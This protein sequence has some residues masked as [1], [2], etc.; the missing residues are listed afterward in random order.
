MQ[1]KG[2]G[3]AVPRAKRESADVTG[4]IT[5]H[6][7]GKV[8]VEGSFNATKAAKVILI[9]KWAVLGLAASGGVA[10]IVKVVYEV[11]K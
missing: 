11:L 2:E 6:D 5:L 7:G 9:I 4:R 10:G 1:E 3:E 8:K